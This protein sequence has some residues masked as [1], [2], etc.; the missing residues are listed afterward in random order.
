MLTTRPDSET[1]RVLTA[2]ATAEQTLEQAF[3]R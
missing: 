1:Q 3:V 2:L